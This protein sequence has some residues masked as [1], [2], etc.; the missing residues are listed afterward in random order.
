MR[1]KLVRADVV[2]LGDWKIQASRQGKYVL[3][4]MYNTTSHEFVIQYVD[5]MMKVNAIV[6]YVIEKG[7][8]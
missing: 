5:D 4:L 6:E 7:T 2:L 3:L 1:K 8:L